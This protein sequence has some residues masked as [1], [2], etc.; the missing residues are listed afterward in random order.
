[1]RVLMLR[2]GQTPS[3]VRGLLD[4]GAP[5]P[6][7]TPLG[8]R[9]AEAVP[10]ALRDRELDA[11]V[12]SSLVRTSLTAQPLLRERGMESLA[13]SGLA[14]IGAGELEMAEDELSQQAYIE[15]AFAWSDGDLRRRMPG[16]SDGRA[17]FSRFDQAI[18]EIAASGW[19]NVVVVSHG[20]AIRTWSRS[21]VE[22]V[23][24]DA[25]T[26]HHFA[27]T[28]ALEMEGDPSTGWRLLDWTSD[29]IG[30]AQLASEIAEDP[31]GEPA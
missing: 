6:G 8:Q 17:F 11:V 18:A 16:G 5:G 25:L 2:H 24:V 7:L 9:Q 14:E 19:R 31:T 15:T 23:D 21:R 3:N 27:N 4:T 12:V 29:P 10:Q 28:G 13:L 20:A 30:G 22:G 26:R 1:M